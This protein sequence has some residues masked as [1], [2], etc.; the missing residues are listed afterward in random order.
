M[1]LAAAAAAFLPAP[2]ASAATS[3]WRP[4][5][6]T[7][8]QWQLSG[9]VDVTVPAEVFD[10]DAEV[11][12]A[13]T[14]AELHRRGA[15]VI[16]YIDVGTWEGYRRDAAAFP[17]SVLGNR[18]D[19]WDQER[20]LDIRQRSV[21]LPIME[22]RIAACAAKGFDAVEPDLVEG[23][24]S[25]TGFP[26]TAADQLAYNRA[27]AD[28][29]HKYGLGVGLKNDAGQVTQL[30]PYFD[31]AVVEECAVYNEC[32]AYLPFIRAGKAVLHVEY[33]GSTSS[34]CPTTTALGFSSMKKR[35][36]LDAWR[37]VCPPAVPLTSPVR[38]IVMTADMTG[39]ARADAF[40]VDSA[41]RLYL[42][43]GDGTGRL[44]TARHVGP[45]WG[46][47]R[48][49]A[50]GDW[51]GDGRADLVA[52]DPAGDLWLY[53]GRGNGT[54]GA[55]AKIGNGWSTF[56]IVPAGDMNGDRKVDL[57]GIDA[58]GRLWLYPGAGLG[59]FG[60]RV[61]VGNGWI[62]YDLYAAGDANRDG[63]NDI[64]SVDSAGKLWYYA[65]RGG[66]FFATRKQVGNGWTGFT[67][68]S[69][70]DLNRDGFGDLLGR[71]P[72]GRLYFYAGR[73]G[74]TFAQRVQVGN[75]W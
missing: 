35:V 44:G 46:S 18:V 15:K 47:M 17:A 74:G 69:G 58:Q 37:E 55:R 34:F 52:A 56:R 61:Q 40:A 53:P 42:F 60:K 14:V 64:F 29:A 11:N 19:G 31:F 41:G 45:G 57:L 43:P 32:S 27:I 38:Q 73:L 1:A 39:D 26:I 5:V 21:L 59:K 13:A 50:P 28:L 20:W 66:G 48:V 51:N 62:G 8:W 72:S 30:E 63:R 25:N 22:A 36:S 75:G 3:W 6:G 54:L 23:Y 7:T 12:T 70:A 71:D 65:G 24:R 16:C 4:A 67:F 10:I 9:T 68:A 33:A 49:F 2:V